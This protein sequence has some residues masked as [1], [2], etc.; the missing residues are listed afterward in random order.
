MEEMESDNKAGSADREQ[1]ET[2][3]TVDAKLY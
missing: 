3:K 2:D 1:R